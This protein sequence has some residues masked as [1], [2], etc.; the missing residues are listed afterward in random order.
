MDLAVELAAIWR[1]MNQDNDIR[2]KGTV[3]LSP[4]V[5]WIS[6]TIRYDEILVTCYIDVIS[7]AV[8][9]PQKVIFK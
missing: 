9:V 2:E 4:V 1:K 7:V 3:S 8:G 5:I 6:F